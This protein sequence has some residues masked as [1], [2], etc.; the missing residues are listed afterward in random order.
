MI[1]QSSGNILSQ[2]QGQV[3]KDVANQIA[4][5]AAER[6]VGTGSIGSPD[7][8][9][10]LLRSLGLTSLGL[11][12]QG[13][14]N[15]TGAIARTPTGQQFNPQQFLVTPGQQQEA[16]YLANL[17]SAA[18]DPAAAANAALRNAKQGFQTGLGSLGGGFRGGFGGGPVDPLGF[19]IEP[20]TAP[21]FSQGAGGEFVYGATGTPGQ[22][23]L[24]GGTIG[25]G[26]PYPWQPNA[27]SS[28]Y[29][30]LEEEFFSDLGGGDTSGAGTD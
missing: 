10:A 17:Y 19:P 24:G 8:N 29:T 7:A 6:G 21:G 13:E 25:G 16:Q 1:G 28:P 11:E 14:Q 20:T 30:D 2:L 3:P 26:V 27:T 15:L 22:H 23:G 9:T 5:M 4:Q 12:Q 18:P